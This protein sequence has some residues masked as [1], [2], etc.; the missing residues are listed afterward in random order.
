M[1][2]AQLWSGTRAEEWEAGAKP[3]GSTGEICIPSCGGQAAVSGFEVGCCHD[4][5][6]LKGAEN[7]L[8][9]EKHRCGEMNEHILRP[10]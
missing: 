4:R 6:L 7:G 1:V 9:G 5:C 8:L 3:C 2:R 10:S